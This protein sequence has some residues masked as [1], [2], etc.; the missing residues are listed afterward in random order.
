MLKRTGESGFT[1]IELL[2][3]VVVMGL[4]LAII[5]PRAQRAQVQT[6]Y[7]SVRQNGV[8]LAAFAIQWV[9]QG[10]EAQTENSGSKNI[11]YFSSLAGLIGPA[12]ITN[13]ANYEWI[14]DDGD[15][16]NWNNNA[17]NLVYVRG[18]NNST[19][20]AG[21]PDMTVQDLIDPG[22][23][24]RN[25]FNGISV[26]HPKNYPYPQVAPVPGSLAFAGIDDNTR[27]GGWV[28]F[29]LLFQGTD[30]LSFNAGG[31]TSNANT[32]YGGMNNPA[33]SFSL[34]NLRQGIFVAR[35]SK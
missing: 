24:P 10:I 29:A 33:G 30:S 18:R 9:E 20:A 4:M 35:I 21:A 2:L 19:G 3:V 23:E 11:H 34:G 28:Y 5:V 15:T 31:G 32:F 6:K 14:A 8:E 17:A 1:L 13:F 12:T 27:A 16:C 25:P 7:S 22:K 26:F